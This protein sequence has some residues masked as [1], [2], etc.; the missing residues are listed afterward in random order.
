MN[1]KTLAY[2]LP[3][4]TALTLPASAS[5]HG[6]G[7]HMGGFHG[8]GFRGGSAFHAGGNNHGFRGGRERFFSNGAWYWCTPYAYEVGICP[9]D[10]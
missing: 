3:I 1:R 4:L 9:Y 2:A 10:Y 5:M 8:G 7:G 6:G